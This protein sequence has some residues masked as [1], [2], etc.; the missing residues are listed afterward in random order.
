MANEKFK[1]KGNDKIRNSE[2]EIEVNDSYEA[3]SKPI[4]KDN[5]KIPGGE[6]VWFNNFGIRDKQTKENKNVT[7]TG[8]L[9]ALPDNKLLFVLYPDNPVPQEVKTEPVG[10]S[11]KIRFTLSIG[12]PPIGSGP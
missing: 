5:T 9:D 7:Y 1:I 3:Y 2:I 11:G 8:T 10:N 12:D 6:V 4:P